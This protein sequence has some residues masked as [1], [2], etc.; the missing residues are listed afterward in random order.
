MTCRHVM[1][2]HHAMTC[3]H[4]M[5]Y[6]HAMA[7]HQMK[8]CYHEMMRRHAMTCH[9]GATWHHAMTY[10]HVMVC[11]QMMS[12]YHAMTCRHAMTRPVAPPPARPAPA[13]RKHGVRTLS[14]RRHGSPPPIKSP[15]WQN[16]GHGVF[17]RKITEMTP[18]PCCARECRAVLW[19]T[20]LASTTQQHAEVCVCACVRD[21]VHAL[22]EQIVPD[23]ALRCTRHHTIS[24]NKKQYTPHTRREM[25]VDP[26]LPP[27][28]VE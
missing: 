13:R 27:R 22:L 18:P 6:H 14:L 25:R 12:C 16:H 23:H 7:C 15:F 24:H 21:C 2:R 28:A 11:H 4:A 9:H 3:H 19:C 8:R 26:D 5:T 20:V 17:S 1:T 10:R